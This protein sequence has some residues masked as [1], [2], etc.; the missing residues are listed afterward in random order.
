MSSDPT[1]RHHA[2]PGGGVVADVHNWVGSM[3]IL[4]L[5]RLV[6]QCHLHYLTQMP[7]GPQQ[8]ATSLTAPGMLGQSMCAQEEHSNHRLIMHAAPI[9]FTEWHCPGEWVNV[10]IPPITFTLGEWVN[11]SIH[12]SHLLS[13][14]ALGS[15]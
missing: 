9:T 10:S 8:R 14:I 4:A 7:V 15:G 13:G 3:G 12:P 6:L 2:H 11:V 1:T 5:A